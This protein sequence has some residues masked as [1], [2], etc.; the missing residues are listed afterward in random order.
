MKNHGWAISATEFVEEPDFDRS[1][2]DIEEAA[3]HAL[4]LSEK[5]SLLQTL[6]ESRKENRDSVYQ[7]P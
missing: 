7:S 3:D 4:V 5:C 6:R 1:F 2:S